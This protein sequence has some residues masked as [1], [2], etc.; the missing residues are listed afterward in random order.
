MRETE[1]SVTTAYAAGC[2]NHGAVHLEENDSVSNSRARPR[3]DPVGPSWSHAA[4]DVS[5]SA[6]PPVTW[7]D[8]YVSVGEIDAVF[9]D[10]PCS[11]YPFARLDRRTYGD[12]AMLTMTLALY[13]PVTGAFDPSPLFPPSA[14]ATHYD[15]PFGG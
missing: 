15:Y 3:R 14:S 7:S 11:P 2:E 9:R 12:D 6:P 4:V 10:P 8:S 5:V 13:D 1:N